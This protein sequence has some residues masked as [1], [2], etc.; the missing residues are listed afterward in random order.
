MPTIRR[1]CSTASTTGIWNPRSRT[2]SHRYSVD[3]FAGKF[4]NKTALRQRLLWQDRSKP[5]VGGGQRLD[6]Q[7]GVQ[8]IS[9]AISTR[10]PTAPSSCCWAR[11]G[12]GHQR[13]LLALKHRLNDKTR[14]PPRDRHHDEELSHLYLTAGADI[15]VIPSAVRA[16]RP[17]AII[18]MKVQATVPV[19]RSSRRPGG[20]RV[21]APT[22]PQALRRR[23]GFTVRDFSDVPGWRARWGEPSGLVIRYPRYFHQLRQN[24]MRQD[25]SWSSPAGHYINI[26]N[27]I[28]A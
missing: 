26:Y 19:V 5:I 16:L 4:R 21:H 28:R 7:K 23:T 20:H 17:Y 15:W 18:A 13:P 11:L 2:T 12:E 3:A 8:L 9:H 25:Y 10:W 14:L 1:A 24:G 22:T 6:Q 27:H